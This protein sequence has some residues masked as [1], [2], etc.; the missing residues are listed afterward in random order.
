M[1][2]KPTSIWRDYC[3]DGAIIRRKKVKKVV[4]KRKK[5]VVVTIHNGV[6]YMM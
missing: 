3:G 2:N 1:K 4:P 6:D 5:K